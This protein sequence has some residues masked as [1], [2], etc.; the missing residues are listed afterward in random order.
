MRYILSLLATATLA[1]GLQAFAA[2]P[3][4][5]FTPAQTKQIQQIVQQYLLDNPQILME[6]AQKLQQEQAA[7]DKQTQIQAKKT[8]PT[9]AGE[10]L[11]NP[12]TPVGGNVNGNVTLVEFFD[13]QCSHCR[14]MAGTVTKLMQQNP[15]LRVV[16]KEFPIGG[17]ASVIAA[18][19]ALAAG[20]QGKYQAM[21]DAL[22]QAP[23]PFSEQTILA[24]AQAQGLNIKQLQ[25]DM[26]SPAIAAELKQNG[27][28]GKQL[29]LLGTPAFIVSPTASQDTNQATLIPGAVDITTLQQLISQ[30][31]A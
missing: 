12:G 23:I 6:M 18:E 9:L 19:A 13:Y 11:Q 7:Q 22:L 2:D 10:L 15:N 28:L 16:Y 25:T 29:H 20:M 1:F 24:T 21:H 8:I 14:E 5:A 31:K 30:V 26:K 17:D 27:V 4:A 3:S